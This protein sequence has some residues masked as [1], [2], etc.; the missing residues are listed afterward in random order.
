[1][2]E[3]LIVS[4]FSRFLLE[5]GIVGTCSESISEVRLDLSRSRFEDDLTLRER[6]FGLVIRIPIY[7]IDMTNLWHCL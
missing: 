1:M 3:C 6:P 2:R 4:T 5:K 7:N